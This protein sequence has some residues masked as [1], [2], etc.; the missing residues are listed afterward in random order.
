MKK[1]TF[2]MILFFVTNLFA[3]NFPYNNTLWLKSLVKSGTEKDE[4]LNK[5]YP[6]KFTQNYL[7]ENSMGG[8]NELFIVYKAVKEKDTQSS[9]FKSNGFNRSNEFSVNNLKSNSKDFKLRSGDAN[10]ILHFNYYTSSDLLN[11]YNTNGN[12][13]FIYEIL[14]FNYKLNDNSKNQILTYLSLKYGIEL[15]ELKFYED[16]KGD[17]LWKEDVDKKYNNNITGI[18]KI[19]NFKSNIYSSVKNFETGTMEIKVSEKCKK[20]LSQEFYFLVGTNRSKSEL[21]YK[22]DGSIRK[23][24]LSWLVQSKNSEKLYLDFTLNLNAE[25]SAATLV[26]KDVD[27]EVIK[28]V[29]GT[30]NKDSTLFFKDVSLNFNKNIFKIELLEDEKGLDFN[31]EL[32]KNCE[33]GTSATIVTNQKSNNIKLEIFNEEKQKLKEYHAL[34]ANTL[35]TGLEAGI[36][37]FKITDGKVSTEKEVYIKK[38]ISNSG[39]C[40]LD[41]TYYITD[42]LPVK[43][44]PEWFNKE[45]ITGTRWYHNGSFI[46][47]DNYIETILPGTYTLLVGYG[48]CE[49]AYTTSVTKLIS[50]NESYWTVYPNPV[51]MDNNF[52]ISYNLDKESKVKVIIYNENGKVIIN[53][54]LGSFSSKSFEFR[55]NTSGIYIIMSSIGSNKTYKKLIVK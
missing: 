43:I 44:I 54:E 34:S 7:K 6:L 21:G 42:H 23:I 27:D 51:D 38:E 33:G 40:N 8:M 3:Q 52:T 20:D 30:A 17:R 19:E 12:D 5:F 15:K 14:N 9:I 53:R 48:A 31:V 11:F 37:I 16:S 36:Y 24:D 47:D 2:V 41:E 13:V 49:A 25:T 10:N 29:Y 35:I 26:F 39:S 1:I 32:V 46:S 50:V 22:G 45:N 28:K 55:L 18:A 4:T